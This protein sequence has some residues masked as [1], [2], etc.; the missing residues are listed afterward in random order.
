M[1]WID[2]FLSNYKSK[3]LAI[4]IFADEKLLDLNVKKLV[5]YEEFASVSLED[6][7]MF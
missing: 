6:F 7:C 3:T 4:L 5:I 1:Y 2:T